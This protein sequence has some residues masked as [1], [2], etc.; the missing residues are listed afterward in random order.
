M[1]FF[2]I[3]RKEAEKILPY[4]SRE[5]GEADEKRLDSDRLRR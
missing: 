5:G 1:K 4:N 3:K 2:D